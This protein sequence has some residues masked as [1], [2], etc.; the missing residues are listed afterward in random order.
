MLCGIY[1]FWDLH[2]EYQCGH[3]PRASH[4]DR[5]PTTPAYSASDPHSGILI[6]GTLGTGTES[7]HFETSIDLGP[8]VRARDPLL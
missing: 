1:S 8:G 2:R 5:T 6:L 7:T 3:D 4:L